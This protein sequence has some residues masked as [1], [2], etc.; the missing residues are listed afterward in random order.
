[1]YSTQDTQHDKDLA[2][3]GAVTVP[4]GALSVFWV[5]QSQGKHNLQL[6]SLK[7]TVNFLFFFGCSITETCLLTER[8]TTH[9]SHIRQKSH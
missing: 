6:P 9:P 3:H 5:L 2:K 1:M 8:G 4:L 7:T